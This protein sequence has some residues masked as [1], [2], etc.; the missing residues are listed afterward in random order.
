MDANVWPTLFRSHNCNGGSPTMSWQLC[1]K[2]SYQLVVLRNLWLSTSPRLAFNCF[3]SIIICHCD[4]LCLFSSSFSS[5]F[6]LVFWGLR[7]QFLFFCLGNKFK[8][9]ILM[10]VVLGLFHL[11][12]WLLLPFSI[13]VYSIY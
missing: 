11:V 6:P 8:I 5:G 9:L 4:C 7:N 1:D 13:S 12:C 10:R 2:V 3:H